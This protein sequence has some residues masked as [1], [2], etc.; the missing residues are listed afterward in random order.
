MSSEKRNIIVP[1]DFSDQSKIA[2]SQTYNL[3]K[4]AHADITLLHVID[5][6]LFKSFLHLFKN[7]EEQE[8]MILEEAR[9]K[10]EE[11]ANEARKKSG[12]VFN[13]QVERGKIYETVTQVAEELDAMFIVM[14]T[15]G[16]SSLKKKFI[17]SNAVRVIG[18]AHCPV[19][20]IKGQQHRS[21]CDVILL[22]LDLSK[23]TK[24]KV[25][26]CI[27]IAKFFKSIVKVVTVV[28]TSDEFLINKMERQ[29]DQVLNF[30]KDHEITCTGEFLKGNDISDEVLAHANEIN[31]DLIMI[32]TQQELEWTEY[33]IGTESQQIIN[34]SE[35]PVCSIRPI[36]R[37]DMTEFVIS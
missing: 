19:I 34:N 37:K 21:G 4:M 16:E 17:G 20:T 13:C 27:E 6:A 30:I 35:I 18:D 2:L 31:A 23:E 10:L 9:T 15:A 14:G 36:K 11:F 3:A 29:M 1:V 22:P 24:E 26:K 28:T 33:F 7:N 12:L 32:M 8:A 5:E 25:V